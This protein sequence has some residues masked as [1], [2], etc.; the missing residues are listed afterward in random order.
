MKLFFKFLYMTTF[1]CALTSAAQALANYKVP[2]Y[3]PADKNNV[4][5]LP[6]RFEYS[7]LDESKIRIGD[8]LIDADQVELKLLSTD[9]PGK[10]KFLFSWPAALL[11]E[12]EMYVKDHTGRA[13][14]LTKINQEKVRIINKQL[15]DALVRDA[16]AEFESEE[17]EDTVVDS[18]RLLPYLN[19]CVFRQTNNTKIYLCSKDLYVP[20]KKVQGRLQQFLPRQSTRTAA[21]AV[22]NGKEVGLQ[23]IIFLNKVSDSIKFKAIAQSGASIEIETRR[24]DVDF[25]D[26]VINT[27]E[28]LLTFT[29]SG[30]EPVNEASVKRINDEEWKISVPIDRPII[31]LKGEGDIPMRQEFFIKGNVPDEDL[32][33]FFEKMPPQKTYSRTLVINAKKPSKNQL[34][35]IEP[36]SNFKAEGNE[37]FEWNIEALPAGEV[38]RRHLGL[39]S[40]G[41][42]YALGFDIY[43]GYPFR[44]SFGLVSPLL[45]TQKPEPT[46]TAKPKSS[47]MH[48]ALRLNW[49][50]ENFLLINSDATRM[51]WGVQ[52]ESKTQTGANTTETKTNHSELALHYRFI[53]GLDLLDPTWGASLLSHSLSSTGSSATLSGLGLFKTSL[54]QGFFNNSIFT[55]KYWLSGSGIAGAQLQPSYSFGLEGQKNFSSALYLQM[56]ANYDSIG[57][58]FSGLNVQDSRLSFKLGVGY[59]F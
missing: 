54:H 23:G 24:K 44:M 21:E 39:V 18:L 47:S 1:Y 46:D 7:I 12:G 48:S 8:I 57:W 43:R 26:V 27:E 22:I 11:T 45:V 42:T 55:F 50:F 58:K 35:N 36:N 6:Q 51:R 20:R 32:R 56:A 53:A 17:L 41:E 9:K 37:K 59:R 2:I 4:S 31:Y 15:G 30:A 13:M 3:F 29:A 5:V 49:W 14:Y 16:I 52:Y 25:K 28:K 10:Y 40:N 38:S 33:A 34:K 19:F